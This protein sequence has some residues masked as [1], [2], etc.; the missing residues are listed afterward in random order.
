MN[1][2]SDL[3]EEYRRAPGKQSLARLLEQHQGSVLGVCRRVL[4]HPQDAEDACQEV[5]LELARQV[6]SIQDARAFRSWLYQ[7]AFH[8]ALDVRRQR[9]RQRAKTA[10]APAMSPGP[11]APDLTETLYEGLARLD[12]TSRTLVVEHYLAERPL[13]ELAAERGCSPVAVWKRIRSVRERL[14]RTIGSTAMAALGPG[15]GGLWKT[16]LGAMGGPAMTGFKVAVAIPVLLVAGTGVLLYA[17]PSEAPPPVLAKR[18]PS[19]PLTTPRLAQAAPPSPPS[20]PPVRPAPEKAES[21]RKPYPYSAATLGAPNAVLLAWSNLRTKH[22]TLDAQDAALPELLNEIT[23]Q[24]G[25]AFK[26]DPDLLQ[27]DQRVSMIVQSIAAEGCLQLMLLPRG[28]DFEI[29]SDGRIRVAMKDL[30]RGGFEREARAAEAPLQELAFVSLLLD[31]GWDGVQDP[32][33]RSVGVQALLTKKIVLPQ[34]ESSLE[35]EIDR[36]GKSEGVQVQVD[37][38]TPEDLGSFK[39]LR[40][41]M[42]QRFLQPV[43]ERLLGEHLDQLGKRAG[44]VPVVLT[45]G[46]VLLTTPEKAAEVRA[47]A[48]EQQRAYRQSVQVLDQPLPGGG[49]YSVQDL[50]AEWQATPGIAVIPSEEAWGSGATVRI[51]KGTTIRQALNAQGFRWAMRDGKIFLL[52]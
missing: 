10:R 12:E 51:P 40:A 17:R 30:I 44:L 47:R 14:R 19:A 24:T 48:E 26:V 23:K 8:T 27:Q 49:P 9:T 35:A 22:V 3:F 18:L 20:P 25:L 11:A 21:P 7:T 50:V 6:D 38:P 42:S 2:P 33:D 1:P 45:E 29:Q 15:G 16:L 37:L 31:G 4:R 52:K 28:Q 43:E 41:L 46:G 39:S 34:G 13:R 32:N 5:L 36:L